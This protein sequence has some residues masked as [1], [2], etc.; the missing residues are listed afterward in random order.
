M[1]SSS[2]IVLFPF[3]SATI[4]QRPENTYYLSIQ[5]FRELLRRKKHPN[6]YQMRP[7]GLQSRA[8]ALVWK[9]WDHSVS[10]KQGAK[11]SQNHPYWKLY[12]FSEENKQVN[13]METQPKRKS[14]TIPCE[15]IKYEKA[16]CIPSLERCSRIF[17]VFSF[18]LILGNVFL[19]SL[20]FTWG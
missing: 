11:H 20:G 13:Y 2:A 8:L 4:S 12:L 3:P 19:A 10:L 16:H 15:L 6:P 1:F 7:A 17:L 18:F 5:E 14:N 9:K